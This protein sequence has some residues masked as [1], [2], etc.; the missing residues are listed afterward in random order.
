MSNLEKIKQIVAKQLGRDP[1]EFDE[2]TNLAEA[3]YESLDVIETIFAV[4]EEFDISVNFQ[5]NDMDA[6]GV[7]TVGDIVK[8]VEAEVAK[9]A[10][11]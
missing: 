1:E 9:K 6:A 10:G 5:A 3:G 4:E 8:L 7:Q 2:S 11:R